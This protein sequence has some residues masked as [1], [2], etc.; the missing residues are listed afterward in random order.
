MLNTNDTIERLYDKQCIFVQRFSRSTSV[1]DRTTIVRDIVRFASKLDNRA[2][3]SPFATGIFTNAAS[4]LC[5]LDHDRGEEGISQNEDE[6]RNALVF[7]SKA[8]SLKSTNMNALV[9]KFYCLVRLKEF[10][11]ALSTINGFIYPSEYPLEYRSGLQQTLR[12][13]ID[14]ITLS[15]ERFDMSL[16]DLLLSILEK[17][18][19]IICSLSV[20]PECQAKFSYYF[21]TLRVFYQVQLSDPVH[22]LECCEKAYKIYYAHKERFNQVI[23]EADMIFALIENINMAYPHSPQ[24]VSRERL[25]KAIGLYHKAYKL[26]DWNKAPY[27]IKAGHYATLP[28]TL[29]LLKRYD[30]AEKYYL[31]AVQ[32]CPSDVLFFNYASCLHEQ[33][34]DEEALHWAQKALFILEDDSNIC[35]NADIHRELEHYSEAASLYIK[36]ITFLEDSPFKAMS[37]ANPNGEKMIELSTASFDSVNE[38]IQRAYHYLLIMLQKEGDLKKARVYLE[39]AK[40]KLPNDPRWEIWESVLPSFEDAQHRLEETKAALIKA[41][42]ALEIQKTT[43]RTWAMKLI[44][45]QDNSIDLDPNCS[46]DWEKFEREID[47]IIDELAE[48]S[49]QDKKLFKETEKRIK[50]D[51][52]NLDRAAC[53]FL[54]TAETLYQQHQT[55]EIDFAAIVVEYCKVLETQ[56]RSLIGDRLPSNVKMLG[57][58]IQCIADDNISP[59]DRYYIQFTKINEFRKSSAHTGRLRKQDAD[60]IRKI[61]YDLGLLRQLK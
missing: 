13:A 58:I 49:K 37:F 16:H 20:M 59:Y 35:L 54:I 60:E 55:S 6:L 10:P 28:T 33:G 24:G 19:E 26:Y 34:K 47:H 29:R 7:A 56:L 44:K 12:Y 36:H 15:H 40:E 38:N 22:A 17:Y 21:N 57:Q 1:N 14:I 3:S 39:L 52:P 25:D 8:L 61:Y 32:E 31:Q 51:Y 48:R 27:D 53:D 9:Q 42:N 11:E 50:K 18:R 5:M 45:L 23:S 43:T 30:E 41:H 46:E 2:S 4:C